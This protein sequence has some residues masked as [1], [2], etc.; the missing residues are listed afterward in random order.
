MKK[1]F[2]LLTMAGILET[3]FNLP[4]QTF[5]GGVAFTGTTN[6]MLTDGGVVNTNTFYSSWPAKPFTLSQI[7]NT[8]E[9]AIVSYGIKVI[10]EN[11]TN[12][13]FIAKLTNSFS[14]ANGGTN[15]SGSGTWTTNI[16]PMTIAVQIV[17]Y[18]QI[19][20]G[21]TNSNLIYAP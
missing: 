10:G 9:V 21:A 13:V 3:A 8:N 14:L 2:I 5:G 1:L 16:A 4:A 11:G 19:D 12:I 7:S 15:Q 20:I 17:P 18:A 6:A